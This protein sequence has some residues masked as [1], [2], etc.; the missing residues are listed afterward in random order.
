MALLRNQERAPSLLR[1]GGAV[2]GRHGPGTLGREKRA[3]EGRTRAGR[4][5]E[6][7]PSVAPGLSPGARAHGA[8]TRREVMGGGRGRDLH[9]H[10]PS[11]DS[12]TVRPHRASGGGQEGPGEAAW[13][14]GRIWAEVTA[15][16]KCLQRGPGGSGAACRA[17]PTREGQAEPE[18]GAGQENSRTAKPLGVGGA[19]GSSGRWWDRG[20]QAVGGAQGGG[21]D[22]GRGTRAAGLKAPPA[23]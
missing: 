6:P 15:W 2:R 10:V 20:P 23:E 17:S 7:R 19:G 22:P 14:P 16:G 21:G 5:E 3:A 13:N 1:A 8:V 18:E 9:R 12:G 11:S 4:R